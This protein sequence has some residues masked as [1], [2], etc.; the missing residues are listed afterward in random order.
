MKYGAVS[1]QVVEAM[2]KG[3]ML[4]F[5]TDYA[6]AVTGIAGPLGGSVE[7]PVGTTWIAISSTSKI[8]SKK[9]NFGEHRE[10]NI[11]KAS[12]TAMN[13]LR[14]LLQKRQD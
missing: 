5:K 8:I 13:M 14:E 9:Y 10:R 7:K 2:A 12:I 11:T 1:Q 6:I 4:K 3:A